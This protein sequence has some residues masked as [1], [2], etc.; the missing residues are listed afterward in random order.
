VAQLGARLDGIEEVVGSNPIGSTN[1]LSHLRAD[2]SSAAPFCDAVC[3][4]TPRKVPPS[5][6][7]TADR[8]A[9]IRTCE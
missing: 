2:R 7:A 3:D 1:S 8:I 6:A 4:A 5:S 9:S